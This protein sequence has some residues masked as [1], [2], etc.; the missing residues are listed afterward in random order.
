MTGHAEDTLRSAGIAQILNLALAIPA[1]EAVGTEG[2]VAGQNGQILDF[3][4]T[5]VAAICTVV[6]YQRAVAEQQQVRIRIEEGAAR[7]AAE[8]VDMPSVSGEFKG[9]AF[10]EDLSASLA[11][12]YDLV[13]DRRLW[14]GPGTLHDAL[15]IRVG[16][17]A[18][19]AGSASAAASSSPVLCL[20]RRDNW[21]TGRAASVGVLAA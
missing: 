7:V 12:I 6:A 8:A 20:N 4:T 21:Q 15:E 16:E 17:E 13:L 9:L 14:V 1:P 11:R 3:V 19:V 5:V 10:F 18:M 2:L